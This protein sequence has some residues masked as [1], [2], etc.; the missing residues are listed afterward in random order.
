MDQCALP[1][2]VLHK[3]DDSTLGPGKIIEHVLVSISSLGS[4]DDCFQVESEV[5]DIAHK[6]Q[7]FGGA[8]RIRQAKLEEIKAGS[9]SAPRECLTKTVQEFLKKNY[10]LQEHGQPS[11]RQVVIAVGYKAGGADT[12]LA[13]QIANDHPMKGE[14]FFNHCSIYLYR[15][16][17]ISS[18]LQ[19]KVRQCF[20]S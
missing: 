2:E 6:W 11:W 12:E 14:R 8:L 3:V 18:S 15:M 9:G 1:V 7:Q 20:S 4:I 16:N 19:E 5:I 13:L 17:S 10:D